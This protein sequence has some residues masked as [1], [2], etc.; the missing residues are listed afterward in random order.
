MDGKT[1]VNVMKVN[2]IDEITNIKHTIETSDEIDIEPIKSDGKRD[3]L[4]VKN[5]IYGINETEDIVIGYKLKLKDNLFN[6]QTMAL[7]DGGTIEGNK[8]CGTEAGVVV[9]RHLF[10]MEIFT[11][12]KDY[13]R[14][15]GYAKFVYKHCKGKPAKYKVKDGAFMVPEYEAES[16]PF[17][18][19]KPV[20]IEFIK[21]IDEETP[22]SD[23]GV[24]GGK[25]EDTN[26]D[27]GVEITNRVIWTFKEAINQD[28]VTKTNFSVKRKSDNSI[29]DGNVTIDTTKKIVTFIPTSLSVDTTY[30]AEAKAVNK[31]DT[32]GTTTALSTEFKAI[33]IK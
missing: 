18:G 3:I 12:E 23:I 32:S 33:K 8:Y 10:T 29:I 7:I 6:I 25:V 22:I 20:E 28:E 13:S 19:E 27:V 15:S 4:R 11:E 17:R 14:T 5:K 1:L 26:T 30:I 24:D 21:G 16:I 9:E 31:L 2:F